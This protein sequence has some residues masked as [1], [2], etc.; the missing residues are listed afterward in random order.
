MAVAASAAI[1]TTAGMY[2]CTHSDHDATIVANVAMISIA[3]MVGFI[4]LCDAV[5]Y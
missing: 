1:A 4:E 2:I 3:V 5:K